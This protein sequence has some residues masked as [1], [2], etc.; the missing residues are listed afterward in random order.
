ML[1]ID[2]KVLRVLQR[3]RNLI[4]ILYNEASK[5]DKTLKNY[6]DRS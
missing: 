6:V 2:P 3:N 1:A 4:K 5:C